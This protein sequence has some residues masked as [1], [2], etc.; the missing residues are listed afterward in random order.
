MRVDERPAVGV[1]NGITNT[2]AASYIQTSGVAAE[3]PAASK[4]GYYVMTVCYDFYDTKIVVTKHSKVLR[5]KVAKVKSRDGSNT[6]QQKSFPGGMLTLVCS[7]APA[8]LAGAPIRYVFGDERD[9]WA[10]SAG[11]EGVPWRTQNA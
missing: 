2:V 3:I 9:R 11:T 8:K 10:S 7:N 5:D 6:I 1:S 4:T